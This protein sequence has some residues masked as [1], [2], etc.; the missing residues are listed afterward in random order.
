MGLLYFREIGMFFKKFFIGVLWLCVSATAVQAETITHNGVTY[1]TV[2]SPYTGRVWLDRNLGASQVCTAYNDSACYGDYYQWGRG[3]DGHEKQNSATT[4]TQ[5]TDVNSAGS[6]FIKGNG[7]WTSSDHNGIERSSHW[8]AIDGSSVCPIGYKIPTFTE[9]MA[10]T[11][12]HSVKD[13]A[14]AFLNFLKLPSA[15]VRDYS[16]AS[17]EH[18]DQSGYLYAGTHSIFIVF[19]KD[20]AQ[21][22]SC[23]EANALTLRCIESPFISNAGSDQNSTIGQ[24]VTL[25]ASQSS[26][27]DGQIVSYEWKEGD[28]V[29]STDENFTKTDFGVGVHTITLTVTDDDNNSASDEVVVTV[30]WSAETITDIVLPQT[31]VSSISSYTG[32]VYRFELMRDNKAVLVIDAGETTDVSL[33]GY[34]YD[35][36]GTKVSDIADWSKGKNNQLKI[37]KVLDAGVYILKLFTG[38]FNGV[39]SVDIKTYVVDPDTPWSVLA[40]SQYT[41]HKNK[42]F[43]KIFRI[44]KSKLDVDYDNLIVTVSGSDNVHLDVQKKD[45]KGNALD[46]YRYKLIGDALTNSTDITLHIAD[47]SNAFSVDLPVHLKVEAYEIQNM[48]PNDPMIIANGDDITYPLSLTFDAITPDGSTVKPTCKTTIPW[49]GGYKTIDLNVGWATRDTT[50]NRYTCDIGL[51][52]LD[53]KTLF[54]IIAHMDELSVDIG[55][56]DTES[57]YKTVTAPVFT[58]DVLTAKA[59]LEFVGKGGEYDPYA[60][61]YPSFVVVNKRL[62][63]YTFL[64]SREYLPKIIY[65]GGEHAL[66]GTRKF[67]K[68]MVYLEGGPWKLTYQGHEAIIETGHYGIY[69]DVDG[70]ID[71]TQAAEVVKFTVDP[72]SSFRMLVKKATRFNRTARLSVRSY[73]FDNG[74]ESET[75]SLPRYHFT[76]CDI[77]ESPLSMAETEAGV[78]HTCSAESGEYDE[79]YED[80]DSAVRGTTFTI[81]KE[82]NK[83]LVFNLIEGEIELS[84]SSLDG[85]ITL[86]D[87]ESLDLN[88]TAKTK[89]TTNVLSPLQEQHLADT[90]LNTADENTSIGSINVTT[91]LSNASYVLVGDNVQAGNG[92]VSV[93]EEVAEGSYVLQFLPILGFTTP[94]KIDISLAKTNLHKVYAVV[95][96]VDNDNDGVPDSLDAFPN[97][98]NESVDT[99]HDGI[100]NNAD[101]DDDNDGVLD[102]NDALPLNPNESVDTD[103]DGIGNNADRDDDNDG[104]SDVLERTNGLNPLNASDGEAD[105][106]HD[107]FSNAL[108]ISVGTDIRSAGSKP[109]WTPVMMGDTIMFV[110]AKP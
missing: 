84:S 61:K 88:H 20:E 6:S 3:A 8:L 7:D 28:V 19:D 24:H 73:I 4:S 65:L 33:R 67:N 96:K 71:P 68:D 30:E 10:E 70:T 5:S 16:S 75:W 44:E 51:S 97:N 37:E 95:Y 35:V 21:W 92:K 34:L 29:L 63:P 98:A 77:K 79:N 86:H 1:G 110:P 43:T 22:S 100:G 23:G 103:H 104:I 49:E 17:I 32:K 99:D 18:K 69:I 102:V 9:L 31:V 36:N 66:H 53:D 46:E 42:L 52:Q 2:T 14:T 12:E 45:D 76:D 91:N 47:S 27:S 108:E 13:R 26:D 85:N 74:D 57:V 83:S 41:I 94:E 56:E 48:F 101:T 38:G 58:R 72:N 90:S 25:S 105:F 64:N 107:G 50:N 55:F 54:P 78:H 39:F 59:T 60:L 109:I 89:I 15:G 11:L 82:S 81:E 62:Y 80:I 93:F 106:D 87:M 40:Q